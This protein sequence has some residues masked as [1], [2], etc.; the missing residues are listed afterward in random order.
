MSK[1]QA[2]IIRILEDGTES[3][4]YIDLPDSKVTKSKPDKDTKKSSRKQKNEDNK[5]QKE[6]QTTSTSK[7][8]ISIKRTKS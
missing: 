1:R 2:K 5:K 6:K 4:E 8:P 3:V 7:A